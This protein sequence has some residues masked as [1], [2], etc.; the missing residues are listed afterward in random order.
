MGVVG[1]EPPTFLFAQ[2]NKNVSLIKNPDPL[3]KNRFG[4]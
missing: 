4:H 1:Y 2:D 3:E